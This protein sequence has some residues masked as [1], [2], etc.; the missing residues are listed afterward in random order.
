MKGRCSW[1]TKVQLQANIYIHHWPTT[2]IRAI[3]QVDSTVS[4]Q[5]R[6]CV[7]KLAYGYIADETLEKLAGWIPALLRG[8]LCPH[9][10]VDF[11][12]IFHDCTNMKLSPAVYVHVTGIYS[13]DLSSTSYKGESPAFSYFYSRENIIVPLLQRY[14]TKNSRCN[15]KGLLAFFFFTLLEKLAVLEP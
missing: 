4:G 15:Q 12:T 5:A 11:I 9:N 7:F 3:T 14:N 13:S 6:I 1:L 2:S 10:S 8:I